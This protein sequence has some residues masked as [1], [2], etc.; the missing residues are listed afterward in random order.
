MLTV[1]DKVDHPPSR[2]HRSQTWFQFRHSDKFLSKLLSKESEPIGNTRNPSF[3]VYYN[4]SISSVPF[5]WE[6]TP[7]TPKHALFG[8]DASR[9]VVPPLT[10]P[11]SFFSNC[12]GS[13]SGRSGSRKLLEGFFMRCRIKSAIA[14]MSP[15]R[16]LPASSPSSNSVSS[17]SSSDV[18]RKAPNCR[19]SAVRLS[20]RKWFLSKATSFRRCFSS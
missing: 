13:R 5:N 7:G 1:A 19:R 6:T 20:R 4:D 14:H 11:P 18:D 10:P 3:R 8:D 12:S 16:Y 2:H 9:V 15:L 17:E